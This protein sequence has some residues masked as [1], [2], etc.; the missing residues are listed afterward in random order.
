MARAGWAVGGLLVTLPLAFGL[1]QPEIPPAIRL[2]LSIV[3]LGALWRPTVALCGVLC[4]MPVATP[5]LTSAGPTPMTGD[6]LTDALAAAVVGG[7][8]LRTAWRYAP[9]PTRLAWPAL[10]L[11]AVVASSAIVDLSVTHLL[12]PSTSEFAADLWRHVSS[13]YFTDQRTLP[14]WHMSVHWM[15]ALAFAVLLERTTRRVPGAGHRLAWSA[16]LGVLAAGTFSVLRLHEIVMRA[17]DRGEAL[18]RHLTSTRIS[19]FL[20]DVNATGSLLALA[21]ACWAVAVFAP[22]RPLATRVLAAWPMAVTGLALWMTGSRA[23]QIAAVAGLAAGLLWL[24]RTRLRVTAIAAGALVLITGAAT[25]LLPARSTQSDAASSLAVRLDMAAVSLQVTRT[26][27]MFGVGATRFREASVPFVSDALVARFP[28]ARVGENAHNQILQVLGEWGVVGLLAVGWLLIASAGGLMTQER[29]VWHAAVVAGWVAF[30]LSALSGHPW[31]IGSVVLLTVPLLGLVASG[32]GVRPLPAWGRRALTLAVLALGISLPVRTHDRRTSTDLDNH[33]IG[34]SRTAG[35]QD[36]VSYRIAE[37]RSTWFVRVD[38]QVIEIPL[39]VDDTSPTTRCQV[40]LVVDGF[41]ANSLA[42]GLEEWTR[43]RFAMAAGK[44]RQVNRRIDI[45]AEP[46]TC[47]LRVGH[48]T[49]L[50]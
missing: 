23:A 19:P 11:G 16:A 49:T 28:Q 43:V 33:V 24:S 25:I 35:T 27:P 14:S 4:L 26:A 20:P 15:Q 32:G 17:P 31:L 8:A 13:T 39:R 10:I 2:L 12:S 6:G 29:L 9:V 18:L 38:A 7:A 1:F 40:T 5:I 45:V 30:F 21:T 44:Y 46:D 41:P 48:L 3:W 50:D 22:T 47:R 42:V 36:G 34:A 37:A